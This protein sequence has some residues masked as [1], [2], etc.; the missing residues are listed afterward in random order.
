MRVI[1]TVL[2]LLGCALS[3]GAQ[4]TVRYIVQLT[5]PPVL[6][7]PGDKSALSRIEREHS[8]FEARATAAGYTV[9]RRLTTV[10]NVVIVE[11][12]TGGADALRGM[13]GVKRAFAERRFQQHFDASIPLHQI[14]S[15][16]SA[17]PGA[18]YNASD[19]AAW[20]TAGQGVR[21]RKLRLSA[22]IRPSDAVGGWVPRPT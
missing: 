19:P 16:W 7:S 14:D 22:S 10:A 3:A 20:N 6:A 1:T 2:L 4:Q 13:S 12:P 5:H 18:T 21:A 15:A 11:G 9:V 8:D 17:I